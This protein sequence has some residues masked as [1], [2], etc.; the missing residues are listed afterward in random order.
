MPRTRMPGITVDND[1]RRTIDKEHRGIRIF[2]RLR[3]TSQKRAELRLR[4]EINRAEIEL[5]RKASSHQFV[6]CATRYLVESQTKRTAKV[7]NW[8]I[9]LLN[10]HIGHLDINHIHDATLKSF[11]MERLTANVSA[12]TINRSLEVVRTILH[13][14]ARVYRDDGGRPW[15]PTLPPLITMLP[16]SPRS[17]YPITWEEQDRLFPLLPAYLGCM[18]LFAVNTGLRDNNV[19]GLEWSWEVA[20]PEVGRS[21]FVIPP[22]AFKTKRAHVAILNDTAWSI[23]QSQRGKHPFWVF[24]LRGKRIYQMNNTAWQQARKNVGLHAVRIHDLRHTF[25]SRLRAVG[26]TPEDRQTLLG[27][28][29]SSMAGHYASADIGRLVAQVNLILDR[30]GTRTVLRVANG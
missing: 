8:H 17:P 21:V 9:R 2:A 6:D 30:T 15:L 12:T 27:H 25:A 11:I 5:Q 10:A 14:A 18:V 22:E 19:C 7:I 24:P 13:R 28:S 23:V 1:G 26:V 4:A 16:E 3:S 20:V 29:N